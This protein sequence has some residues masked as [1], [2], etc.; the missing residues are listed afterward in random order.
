[1]N[2]D[3]ILAMPEEKRH[4]LIKAKTLRWDI[5][6]WQSYVISY[7]NGSIVTDEK[8]IQDEVQICKNKLQEIRLELDKLMDENAEF[9]I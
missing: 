2:L 3:K 9:F 7:N 4:I 8:T 1:M 6:Y 5:E